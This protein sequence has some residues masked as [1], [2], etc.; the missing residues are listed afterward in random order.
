MISL[1]FIFEIKLLLYYGDRVLID[2]HYSNIV[3][4][5]FLIFLS[6]WFFLINYLY[7]IKRFV[8]RLDKFFLT[9]SRRDLEYRNIISN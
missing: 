7:L 5:F 8:K 4:Y 9:N 2:I 1:L 3:L 6:S